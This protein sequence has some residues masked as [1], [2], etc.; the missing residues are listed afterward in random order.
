MLLAYCVCIPTYV[1]HLNRNETWRFGIQHI[2][3]TN[4]SRHSK[5][6]GIISCARISK[7]NLHRHVLFIRACEPAK[8]GQRYFFFFIFTA[9]TLVRFAIG[10]ARVQTYRI[11]YTYYWHKHGDILSAL[12][13]A[14]SKT[15]FAIYS[16]NFSAHIIHG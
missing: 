15:V 1:L 9:I 8:P 10:S 6:P 5:Y 16:Y 7:S 14:F 3:N 2:C 11:K 13:R 4:H 12:V